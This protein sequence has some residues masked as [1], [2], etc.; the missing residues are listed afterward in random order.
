MGEV[1]SS[2]LVVP[3]NFSST[4]GRCGLLGAVVSEHP[5]PVDRLMVCIGHRWTPVFVFGAATHRS[6]RPARNQSVLSHPFVSGHLRG[7]AEVAILL[8]KN[9]NRVGDRSAG[10]LHRYNGRYRRCKPTADSATAKR[11]QQ[12]ACKAGQQSAASE[13]QRHSTQNSEERDCPR[14]ADIR[15]RE[16]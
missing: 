8:H 5:I 9:L 10:R 16:A 12:S 14:I 4:P 11:K 15:W 7:S 2:N 1:A 3:T 13:K 6:C